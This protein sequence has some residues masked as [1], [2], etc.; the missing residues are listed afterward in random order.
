MEQ[1]NHR[2]M[3]SSLSEKLPAD[4]KAHG[5]AGLPP[6]TQNQM[7]AA[8]KHIGIALPPSYR[9]FLE[10]A[11]GW[12]RLTDSIDRLLSTEQIDWFRRDNKSWIAAFTRPSQYGELEESPDEEYFSYEVPVEFRN[13]HL[14]ETL[15]ISAVDDAVLLLNPQVIDSAGEWEAWYFANWVPG[16]HRYRSF[17]EMMD[18]L[19]HQFCNIEWKQPLGVIGNLPD[20]YIGGP[21]S[22]RRR[23]A[24]RRRRQAPKILN[25]PLDKWDFD[26]LLALLKH[27]VWE[28]RQEA[29]FGLGKLKDTR[30]VESLLG[31]VGDDSNAAFAAIDALKRL[32]P[33][34]LIAPLLQMLEDP[35]A[36]AWSSAA[37]TLGELGEVRA[38]PLIVAVV[39]DTS[40]NHL[41][42]CELASQFLAGFGPHGF[43][44][45][46]ELL[47]DGTATVRRRAAQSLLYTRDPRTIDVLQTLL[48]DPDSSVREMAEL[49]LDVLH[50]PRSKDP[51]T[52]SNAKGKR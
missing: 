52:R 6:A 4:I 27:D 47:S 23:L 40:P 33:A 9:S 34:R 21:T 8:E 35:S 20:V 10:V 38:I 7:A 39:R 43:D 48:A 50:A 36:I 2:L 22:A 37:A 1:W 41:H 17:F 45:I 32:A 16:A 18:A 15:Q 29:A 44:A 49:S 13:A 42:V 19:Y 30:A 12:H 46:L 24:K 51:R 31:L 26:E 5:W 25:K 11:N 14:K 3:A 28:V